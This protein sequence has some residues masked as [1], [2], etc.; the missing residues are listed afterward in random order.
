MT[1]TPRRPGSTSG[2]TGPGFDV[3]GVDGVGVV[4]SATATASEDCAEV[5]V[6]V[7]VGADRHT[8]CAEENREEESAESAQNSGEGEEQTDQQADCR[9]VHISSFLR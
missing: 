8:G 7:A 4:D 9:A 3:P 6:A 1:S 5:E 2:S